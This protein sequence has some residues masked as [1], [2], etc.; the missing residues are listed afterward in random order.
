[1][2]NHDNNRKLNGSEEE[3]WHW[4]YL[5]QNASAFAKLPPCSHHFLLSLYIYICKIYERRQKKIWYN[6]QS[7]LKMSKTWR[8]YTNL[9]FVVYVISDPDAKTVYF[10]ICIVHW[11][12]HRRTTYILCVQTEAH[13][14]L[15]CMCVPLHVCIHRVGGTPETHDDAACTQ[16]AA[17]EILMQPNLLSINYSFEKLMSSLQHRHRI[18]ES[19]QRYT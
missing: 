12:L 11:Q 16:N 14:R 6:P 10:C 1:M 9:A 8:W 15:Q 13:R 3:L 5:H 17:A 2:E 4:F 19:P 18:V 7:E